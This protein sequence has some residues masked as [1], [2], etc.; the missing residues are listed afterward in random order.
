MCMLIYNCSCKDK[1][2]REHLAASN[3]II[4]K[5]LRAT[6]DHDKEDESFIWVFYIII[7]LISDNLLPVIYESLTVN[8]HFSNITSEQLILFQIIEVEIEK[9]STGKEDGIT[10]LMSKESAVYLT[11][12]LCQL[13]LRIPDFTETTVAPYQIDGIISIV[14]ILA[15]ITSVHSN[16]LQNSIVHAVP[17]FLDLLNKLDK[18]TGTP[19]YTSKRELMRILANIC[20]NNKIVQDAIRENKGVISILNH[21]TINEEAPFLKEHAIFA[22]RNLCEDN[23]ENQKIIAS[24]KVEKVIESDEITAAGISASITTEGNIR[25]KKL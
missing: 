7:S 19:I 23:E 4:S 2:K 25:I 1:R 20:Y 5:V 11:N 12:I 8:G 13:Q 21:C 3:A 22:L 18:T 17:H 6:M 15:H 24:L 9:R 16:E 14:S 10:Q